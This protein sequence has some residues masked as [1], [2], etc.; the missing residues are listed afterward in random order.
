M[1]LS[2]AVA[3]TI[4][5]AARALA[6]FWTGCGKMLR[7]RRAYDALAGLDQRT[8]KDIGAP[9]WLVSDSMEQLPAGPFR[10]ADRWRD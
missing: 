1:R 6:A 9:E 8:L 2:S 10:R 5:L 4:L 7:Q 3:A